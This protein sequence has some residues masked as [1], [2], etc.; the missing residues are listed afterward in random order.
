MI[1]PR[2][3]GEA[4]GMSGFF[5]FA[6]IILGSG[7]AGVWGVVIA[8]PLMAVIHELVSGYLRKKEEE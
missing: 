6:A 7:V 3:V 8:V 4:V 1:Y 5:V 2:V